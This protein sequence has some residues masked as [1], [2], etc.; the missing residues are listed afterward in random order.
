MRNVPPDSRRRSRRDVFGVVVEGQSVRTAADL[1]AG[2]RSV[3]V[4]SCSSLTPPDGGDANLRHRYEDLSQELD[5]IRAAGGSLEIIEPGPEFLRLSGYSTRLM[6]I[7][8]IPEAV[9]IG[10]R[11]AMIEAARLGSWA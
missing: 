6:D 2:A 3:L 7:N 5:T 11:Q 10:R 9:Q 1:V 4:V 8:L